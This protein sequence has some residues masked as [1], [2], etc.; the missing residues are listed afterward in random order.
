MNK[1]NNETKKMINA[2]LEL[3]NWHQSNVKDVEQSKIWVLNWVDTYIKKSM[4]RNKKV[5]WDL[6]IDSIT[7]KINEG[8]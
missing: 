3:W 4:L 1:M 5:Q 6:V 7:L 2:I 8:I